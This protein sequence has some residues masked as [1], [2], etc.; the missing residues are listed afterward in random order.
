[1]PSPASR[2]NKAKILDDEHE[3]R[4]KNDIGEFYLGY[5][6][7]SLAGVSWYHLIH[8]ENMR[9]AQTK[10]RLITTSEQ[11]RSC[12]VLLRLQAAGGTW[13]WSQQPV[14]VA[15][16]QVLGEKEAA[17]LR[18]NSWLYHYYT[19]QSKLQYGLA[20]DTHAHRVHAYYPQVMTYQT[21]P[22]ASYMNPP[23]L[24]GGH[25][26]QSYAAPAAHSPYSLA[27]PS[28]YAHLQHYHHH[29]SVRL[30]HGLDYSRDPAWGYY[31]AAPA[32]S[33]LASAHAGTAPPARSGRASESPSETKRKSPAAPAAHSG[34]AEGGGVAVATPVAVRAA[35]AGVHKGASSPE[36]DQLEAPWKA[37]P[38]QEVPD[39]PE[40]SPYITPPYSAATPTKHHVFSFEHGDP[41]DAHAHQDQHVPSGPPDPR[42]APWYSHAFVS[43]QPS[44]L[45][46][47]DNAR[48]SAAGLT[49]PHTDVFYRSLLVCAS[50]PSL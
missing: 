16:N 9:E 2:A 40:Y 30:Q 11:D 27:S 47:A 14:I 49:P 38:T 33:A 18:A 41:R 20:Y 50:P 15:T 21:D 22:A 10:H 31:D 37:S 12:I 4:V 13:R 8:P 28:A 26:H 29:Y 5:N 19:M 43:F 39:Y 7:S 24:N 48:N 25:Y 46:F 44:V 36:L 3:G 45:S 6:R 35:P 34:V 42:D 1:M 32:S 17:V 23:A